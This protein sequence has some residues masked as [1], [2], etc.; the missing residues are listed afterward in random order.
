MTQSELIQVSALDRKSLH[1]M[2]QGVTFDTA[3]SFRK[4]IQ[5]GLT[6]YARNKGS[7]T[8]GNLDHVQTGALTVLHKIEEW[9]RQAFYTRRMGELLRQEGNLLYRGK[10]A[11]KT[12]V[13]QEWEKLAAQRAY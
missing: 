8:A 11:A 1:K 13:R 5:Q 7:Q 2:L 12:L 6:A 3:M 10:K 9:C 4:E